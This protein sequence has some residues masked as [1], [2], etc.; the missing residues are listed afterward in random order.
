VATL[1]GAFHFHAV[2]LDHTAF[3]NDVTCRP[4]QISIRLDDLQSFHTAQANWT[5][6]PI[7]FVSSDASC[8]TT[9]PGQYGYFNASILTYTEDTLMVT[10][11]GHSIAV[12]HAI[13]EFNVDWGSWTTSNRPNARSSVPPG[14]KRAVSSSNRSHSSSTRASYVYLQLYICCPD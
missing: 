7:V 2:I 3:V 9:Y 13:K 14:L 12:K 1:G 6:G 10:A 8:H 11:K 4:D 5:S